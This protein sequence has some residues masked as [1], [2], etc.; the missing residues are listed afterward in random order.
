MDAY[1]DDLAT[2]IEAL[3]L[4][5]AILVGFSTGGGEVARYIGRHGTGRVAGAVLD[6]RRPAPDAADRRQPGRPPARRVRR[7]SRGLPSPTGH[8][9]S[10][11]SPT[12]RSTAS[13]AP[14]RR[15]RRGCI[16]SWWR[17]GMQS[18]HSNA[19]SASRRSRRPT[20]PTTSPLRRAHPRHARRRRPGGARSRSA[21]GPPQRSSTE[22]ELKVYPGAP[23]GITDTHKDQ[24]NTDL[25]AF[26]RNVS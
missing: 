16:D 6:R 13:T 19:T 5:D 22:R 15:S 10:A 3:D 8:S 11:T 12:D 4:R 17:Q 9:S 2:V 21:A 20:S 7:A 1:A 26:A 14:G 25:L 18:G 24:L 23:H